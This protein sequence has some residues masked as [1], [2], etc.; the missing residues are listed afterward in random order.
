MIESFSELI[1]AYLI[2]SK[3]MFIHYMNCNHMTTNEEFN[4][5]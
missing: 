1:K 2:N 5:K 3:S 4:Y